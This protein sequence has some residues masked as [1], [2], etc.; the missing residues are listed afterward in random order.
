MGTGSS[1]LS[2][3]IPAPASYKV[4]AAVVGNLIPVGTGDLRASL[5][6][7][8]K[9]IPEAAS[10]PAAISCHLILGLLPWTPNPL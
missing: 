6:V 9:F 10:K 1:L 5:K 2:P 7:A 3:P 8:P 4:A